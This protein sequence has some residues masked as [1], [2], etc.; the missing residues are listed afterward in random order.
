MSIKNRVYRIL[1]GHRK[2]YIPSIIF[3]WSIIFLVVTDVFTTIIET[4]PLKEQVL[5][6]FHVL[7]IFTIIVFTVEYI[8]RIWTADLLHSEENPLSARL[9][10]AFTLM[11]I[12]DIMSIVPFYLHFIFPI[13]IDIFRVI[14]IL[15]I[16][17]L[18]K[19]NH[20]VTALAHVMDVLKR[21]ALQLL[22]STFIIFTL[23]TVASVLMYTVEHDAQPEVF[24]NALSGLWWAVTTLSTIGY[25]DIYPVTALGKVLGTIFSLFSIA[26]IAIPTG[27]IS[28]GFIEEDEDDEEIT[29]NHKDKRFCPYCGENI[30][31]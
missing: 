1:H 21:K 16:F 31:K 4:L 19:I 14:R 23:M 11:M 20:Y 7:E 28:A 22:I 12:I 10:Y 18:I 26:L 8:L 17:R 3:S 25:G 9:K 13:K 27:I 6:S 2:N 29:G 15:R 30:E 5:L 24:E